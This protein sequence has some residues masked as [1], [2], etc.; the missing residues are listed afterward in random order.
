MTDQPPE[1]GDTAL[2]FKKVEDQWPP[3]APR[4]TTPSPA[5]AAED[6][7]FAFEAAPRAGAALPAEVTGGAGAS[8]FDPFTSPG[9]ADTT[10]APQATPGPAGGDPAQ[11]TTRRDDPGG[12]GW[13]IRSPR[14]A[15]P[16]L[17]ARDAP[18]AGRPVPAPAPRPFGGGHA[19]KAS[20]TSLVAEAPTRPRARRLIGFGL[21]VVLVTVAV[22][23]VAEWASGLSHA[24]PAIAAPASVGTLTAV[25]TVAT[26]T[27][28]QEIDSQLAADMGATAVVS[29]AYGSAGRPT[30]IVLL[31]Q[32]P[33]LEGQQTLDFASLTH[34]L[35]AG[36]VGVKP[37]AVTATRMGGTTFLCAPASGPPPLTA[38]SICS[39]DDGATVGVAMGFGGASVTATLNEA[40]AARSAGER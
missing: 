21:G 32:A 39:W 24:K 9:R 16:A 38:M 12:P 35:Q 5:E 25:T 18:A 6:L 40:V 15:P 33:G 1:D 8:R 31:V 4:S 29:A 20:R 10:F 14:G 27:A 13:S 36:G 11:A 3:T 30:L 2:W 7:Q 22:F 37:S 19:G 34:G 17:H 23:A 28:L 26:Q